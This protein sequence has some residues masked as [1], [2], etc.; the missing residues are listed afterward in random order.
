M[1]CSGAIGRG[2]ELEKLMQGV[3]DL[4]VVVDAGPG[5]GCGRRLPGDDSCRHP[6]HDLIL[7]WCGP[8]SRLGISEDGWV[9]SVRCGAYSALNTIWE[10][11]R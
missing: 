10:E 11:E 8:S 7:L 1:L 3:R 4:G 5:H 9:T 6:P 2:R